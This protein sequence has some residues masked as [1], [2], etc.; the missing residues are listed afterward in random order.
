[1]SRALSVRL[2]GVGMMQVH[3]DQISDWNWWDVFG[4]PS[5]FAV[6]NCEQTSFCTTYKLLNYLAYRLL[7]QQNI[8]S[9]IIFLDSDGHG[10]PKKDLKKTKAES[11]G[12]I[13]SSK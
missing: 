6:A 11:R 13:F 1:M 3:V 9:N 12:S 5:S 4:V 8:G 7:L 10:S 2:E